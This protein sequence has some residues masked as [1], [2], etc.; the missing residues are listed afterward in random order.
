MKRLSYLT[1][2]LVLSI[3]MLASCSGNSQSDEAL[4]NLAVT[5]DTELQS[6][7]K[8]SP[9]WLSVGGVSYEDK[10][11][12]I[13]LCLEQLSAD[14]IEQPLAEY[15]TAI[16]MRSHTGATLDGIVNNLVKTDGKMVIELSDADGA[17]KSFEISASRLRRLVV[18]KLMELDY[19]AVKENVSDI[20]SGNCETYSADMR[21]A[22]CDF[23]LNGGFAQYTLTFPA[24]T[25][26]AQY[27]T[28]SLAGRFLKI[29]RP[30]YEKMGDCEPIV[31][32]LMESL[33]IDGY[34]F[35]CT[36]QDGKTLRAPIAWRLL[37]QAPATTQNNKE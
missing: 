37:D 28:G 6:L 30:A 19:N 10:V 8:G 35:I 12:K 16:Y 24:S 31:R 15:A 32:E 26:Y 13:E 36:A 33:G 5:V 7:A 23:E 29:L 2:S 3:I 21:A 11:F 14:A 9:D 27:T 20:L 22:S 18:A 25:A 17:S 1:I 34:R 4:A